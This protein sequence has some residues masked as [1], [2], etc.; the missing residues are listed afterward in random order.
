MN[1]AQRINEKNGISCLVLMFTFGV[2][3]I[4]MSK[5]AHFLYFLPM[6]EIK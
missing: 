3:V 5:M 4:K 6:G 2:I 1:K